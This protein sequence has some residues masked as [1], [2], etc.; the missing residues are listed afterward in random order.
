MNTFL[1]KLMIE[2]PAATVLVGLL[3]YHERSIEQGKGEVIAGAE[4]R[5]RGDGPLHVARGL[6]GL[7]DCERGVAT[8]AQSVGSVVR[9]QPAT[10]RCPSSR[11][12][13]T[14]PALARALALP[15]VPQD[16]ASSSRRVVPRSTSASPSAISDGMSPRTA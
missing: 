12:S 1:S 15:N 2:F 3:G 11:A 6:P 13:S 9:E 7:A 14:R 16:R 10:A 5:G 4:G 8:N